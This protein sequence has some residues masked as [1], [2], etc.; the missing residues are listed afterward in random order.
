MTYFEESTVI[1]FQGRVYSLD[2]IPKSVASSL[3]TELEKKVEK[4][5]GVPKLEKILNLNEFEHAAQKV[6]PAA[7]WAYYRTGADDEITLNENLQAFKR[8]FFKPRVLRDVG[9]V[10]QSTS[11]LGTKVSLPVYIT[12]FARSN[13][14]HKYAEKN[15]T[16]AAAEAD[17]VQ[18]IPSSSGFSFKEIQQEALPG[19]TQWLQIYMR[20]S[21]REEANSLIK[22]AEEAGNISTL[23]FT[24]DTAQL[25]KR[26]FED[27]FLEQPF[28]KRLPHDPSFSWLDIE[29]Y[30]K[31]T[32]FKIVLKGIQLA[33]DALKAAEVGVDAII[34]SNHGGRQLDSARASIEVLEDVVTTLRQHNLYDNLE[35]FVDGG[36]RRGTDVVKALC[37]GAKG[38]GL[39][40]PF[41]YAASVYGKDGVVKA[42]EILREEIEVALRLLGVTSINELNESYIDS[43]RLSLK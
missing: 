33:E 39:G 30:K 35:I 31:T 9:K 23:V 2:S 15:F 40:R 7:S 38:I 42:I 21:G 17:T 10:D 32:N 6:L 22:E 13:I 3:I 34:V 11:L 4:K 14:G 8:I 29:S 25:G 36:V 5:K 41:L 19:Q 20:A 28:E 37:L 1:V 12:A 18:M 16:W 24:V 26:E 43:R 27:R